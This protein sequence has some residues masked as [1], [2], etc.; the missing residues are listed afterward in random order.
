M[1]EK[2]YRALSPW[3]DFVD[4]QPETMRETLIKVGFPVWQDYGQLEDYAHYTRGEAAEVGTGV[5]DATGRPPHFFD[6]VASDYSHA[7]SLPP[8]LKKAANATGTPSLGTARGCR[9]LALNVHQ[10]MGVRSSLAAGAGDIKAHFG[11]G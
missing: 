5:Q 4:V 3:I 1:A 9:K 2:L 8:S 10:K 11:P 7:F 6:D